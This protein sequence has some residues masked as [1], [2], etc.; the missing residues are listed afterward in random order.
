MIGKRGTVRIRTSSVLR[1]LLAAGIFASAA[2]WQAGTVHA[3]APGDEVVA[4]VGSEVITAR[5][6]VRRISA[7]PGFQLRSFGK[8]GEEIR[9][10]FLER[11]LVRESLLSQGARADKLDEREDVKER[12]LG[13]LRASMLGRAR[14]DAMAEG[15]VTNHDIKAYYDAHASRFH[16]PPRM[17]IWRILVATRKEASDLLDELKQHPEDIG[18]WNDLAREKSIDKTTGMRG[19]NLGF[20]SPDGST[21][22]EDVKVDPVIVQAAAHAEDGKLVPVPVPE[23]DKWAVV[24]RRQTMKPVDRTVQDE[25][26]QIRQVLAK[27]RTEEHVSK[28]LETLRAQYASDVHVELADLVEI[29]GAGDLQQVRRPGTL[30]AVQ[31]IVTN[32][33]P[34]RMPAGMR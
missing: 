33:A 10:T 8:T 29:N 11:V 4:R 24:W 14:A 12:I 26:Q 34:M 15:P 2:T 19:G 1:G 25:A 32:P 22:D 16:T 21:G 23:G 20:V 7:V 9:R 30:P 17:A 13:V 5:E 28:L 31:R 3:D 27:E 18:K 6:L